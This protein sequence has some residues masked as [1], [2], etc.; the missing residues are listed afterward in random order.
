[1]SPANGDGRPRDTEDV[2]CAERLLGDL[3]ARFADVTRSL[4]AFA[5][6]VLLGTL[7][8]IVVAVVASLAAIACQSA[9]PRVYVLGRKP[10][11]DV[12]RPK[13]DEHPEDETFPGLPIVRPEGRTFFANAQRGGEQVR[14]QL[15][16]SES[17][18]VAI[19]FSAGPDIEYSAL[20]MLIEGEERLRERGALLWLVALNP[21]A[22]G[23]VQRSSLGETRG[24]ERMPFNLPTAVERF[25]AG[26]AVG[27]TTV[28]TGPSKAG[29]YLGTTQPADKFQA[30]LTVRSSLH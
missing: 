20:K 25:Q 21:E 29:G 19:D 18:V 14:A 22:L 4:A 27:E 11:A 1:M 8:G 10:G 26:T 15:D 24:R 23:M 2:S 9:H 28:R 6:V 16:V 5:A 12:F 3:A 7:K 17:K 30:L 13:S